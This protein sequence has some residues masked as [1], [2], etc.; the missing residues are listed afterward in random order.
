[1]LTLIFNTT[2]KTVLV[3]SNLVGSTV[4]HE[5]DNVPTVR[6]KEGFYEV[7]QKD[8]SEEVRVYPVARFPISSTIMLIEH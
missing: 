1:M 8:L 7:V 4:I 2:K 6:P 3:Y 5:Y